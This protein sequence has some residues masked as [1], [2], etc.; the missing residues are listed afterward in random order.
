MTVVGMAQQQLR[1]VFFEAFQEILDACRYEDLE[2]TGI[3]DRAVLRRIC[4][5]NH[6]PLPDDILLTIME[7]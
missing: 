7:M 6:L 3:I 4:K 2:N 1:K 5:A